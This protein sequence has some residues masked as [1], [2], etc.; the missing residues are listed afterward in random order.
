MK[1]DSVQRRRVVEGE[2][3][4]PGDRVW[5]PDPKT[6]GT[7]IKQRESP[8]SVVI[9]TSNGQVRGNRWMTRRVLEKTA[10]SPQNKGYESREPTPTRELSPDVPSAPGAS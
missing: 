8:R 6:E 2:E 3:L 4:S 1:F 10:V 5:I 7:V 9:Q